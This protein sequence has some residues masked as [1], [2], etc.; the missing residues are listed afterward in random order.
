[1]RAIQH[2]VNLFLFDIKMIDSHM[3]VQFT[4]KSNAVILENLRKLS[5]SDCNIVVR[6]PIIPGVNDTKKS[7]EAISRL[8][9]EQKNIERIS[10]LSY[11]TLGITKFNCLSQPDFVIQ[12][13]PD[14]NCKIPEIKY[15]LEKKGFFV[16]IGE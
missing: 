8:L 14:S 4:G 6:I 11:H 1:M 15:M 12:K 3:H 5:S 7:I 16:S 13:F 9:E 2:L 10:L